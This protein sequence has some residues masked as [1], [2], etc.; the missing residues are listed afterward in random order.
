MENI[1]K[2]KFNYEN[3]GF[4]RTHYK[5]KY[6]DKIYDI[7]IIHYKNFDEILT[8]TKDGEPNNDLKEGLLVELN[9]KL[10]ITKNKNGYTTLERLSL[11][12][13]I[14]LNNYYKLILKDNVEQNEIYEIILLNKKHNIY[15]F[16]AKI[17]EIKNKIGEYYTI[18]DIFTDKEMENYDFIEIDFD[19]Y[20]EI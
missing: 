17:E 13:N 14:E 11:P 6:N 3:T 5:G 16:Q 8:A 2:L 4:S 18:E 9:N 1:L 7:V 19:E 12:I 20:I 10:Y 15:E